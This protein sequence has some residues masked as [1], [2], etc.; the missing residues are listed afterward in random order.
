MKNKAIFSLL[1]AHYNNAE[2][3]KDCYKSILEQNYENYEVII[4]D[5]FSDVNQYH[6]VQSII[7]GDPRFQIYRNAENKGIGYTKR[8]LVELSSGDICGF[9]DPDDAL[10]INAI[11]IMTQTHLAHPEVGLVYSN[12]TVCDENL[13][14]VK[15]K[16]A[17]QIYDLDEKYYNLQTEISHFATFK[18]SIYKKT[19][20]IDSYLKIAEDKD[21]YM[22]MCEVAPVK[23][24]D[25]N[26]YL[27]RIHDGGISTNKNEEKAFFWHFVALIKM[28][29]RRNINIDTLFL[30]K[31]VERGR[32]E[33]ELK[34]LKEELKKEKEK[35][36]M[37][38][39]SIPVR[40]LNK[41]KLINFYK[42]L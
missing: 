26:L 29:E 5:D 19:L 38:R 28:A 32:I 17:K 13:N 10:E 1:I 23:Y 37:V 36:E 30:E 4:L 22:K 7:R 40:I 9:L 41:L 24:I 15:I 27:Y 20:G 11:N 25:V 3:F 14:R 18:K 2:F 12:F 31:F 35:I 33:M 16:Y 39:N 6:L 42:D 34:E 21:L 8:K